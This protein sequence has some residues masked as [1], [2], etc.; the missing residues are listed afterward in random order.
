MKSFFKWVMK[1][2]IVLVFSSAIV[3]SIH[4]QIINTNVMYLCIVEAVNTNLLAINATEP[5]GF[6]FARTVN[7]FV[8]SNAETPL[9]ADVIHVTSDTQ[10]GTYRRTGDVLRGA[11]TTSN[12][13]EQNNSP[14]QADCE[15]R[16]PQLADLERTILLPISTDQALAVHRANTVI[17]YDNPASTLIIGAVGFYLQTPTVT[18]FPHFQILR[19]S[20]GVDDRVSVALPELATETSFYILSNSRLNQ[21]VTDP[22]GFEE[23]PQF[24]NPIDG[25]IARLVRDQQDFLDT[26]MGSGNF[27]MFVKYGSTEI[28][29]EPGSIINIDRLSAYTP[30]ELEAGIPVHA[31]NCNIDVPY[32]R[33]ENYSHYW[34][35][36][37][38]TR[39]TEAVGQMRD[40]EFVV[41]GVR[42][43]GVLLIQDEGGST[44]AV[45][46]WLV[47]I[48]AP[49][50]CE[51]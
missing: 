26:V 34:Y 21:T 13:S 5:V 50:V 37:N 18:S 30:R 25:V 2:I 38:A 39:N 36:S 49:L 31:M 10:S 4:A 45:A 29:Y 46:A 14:D 43:D 32:V 1:Y 33:E 3:V 12:I 40:K 23:E 47:D 22:D 28:D 11:Y 35:L 51:P 27:R 44:Y 17:E 24:L 48:G 9:I 6:M 15:T 42:D 8:Y 19:F 16:Y 7:V 41:E 20:G